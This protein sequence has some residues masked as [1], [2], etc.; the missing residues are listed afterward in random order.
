ME[1]KRKIILKELNQ[2]D[3]EGKFNFLMEKFIIDDILFNKFCTAPASTKFHHS[4]PGGLYD[5]TMEVFYGVKNVCEVFPELD[6]EVVG[7]G[8]LLHDIGKIYNY[9]LNN[10]KK[11]GTK[12]PALKYKR[13]EEVQWVGDIVRTL[14]MVDNY[15]R[16][17]SPE[18]MDRTDDDLEKYQHIQHIIAS[19]HGEV[20]RGWG[21]SVNPATAEAQ[22]VHFMD[23]ISSRVRTDVPEGIGWKEIFSEG[24]PEVFKKEEKKE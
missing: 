20:R 9:Q 15:F 16:K 4:Y 18:N 12:I 3:G 23:M 21:S 22:I 1:E 8:A 10:P 24:F 5:H 2:L 14:F 6:M 7:I 11:T 13:R 19:H 17:Y